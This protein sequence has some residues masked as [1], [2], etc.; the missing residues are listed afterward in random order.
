MEILQCYRIQP[1]FQALSGHMNSKTKWLKRPS[2]LR[3]LAIVPNLIWAREI[4]IFRTKIL[5]KNY[6]R[7]SDLKDLI[8]IAITEQMFL[9][10]LI[11]V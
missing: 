4:L 1:W 6:F 2:Q 9:I 10:V 8:A 7:M 5:R 3:L 11:L